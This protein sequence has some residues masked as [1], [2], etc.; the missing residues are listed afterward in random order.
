MQKTLIR[1]IV[2]NPEKYILRLESITFLIII[3][4]SD[5]KYI[6]VYGDYK[7]IE[8]LTRVLEKHPIL[9]ED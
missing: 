2:E 4:K 1:Y 5:N 3:R 7:D 6:N 9:L 8:Y